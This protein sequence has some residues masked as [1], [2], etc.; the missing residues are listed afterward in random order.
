MWGDE[1]GICDISHITNAQNGKYWKDEPLEFFRLK[2]KEEA[3][4]KRKLE[5]KTLLFKTVADQ[6]G[7]IFDPNK[8]T[9]V[10]ARRFAGYKRP[11]LIT[12]DIERFD[13]LMKSDKVQI[14]W[15]GKPYPFD[16]G[17]IDTFNNLYYMSHLYKNM[18]VLTGHELHLSKLIKDG[19]DVWLNNPVVTREASGTSGMTA[20]M[21]A[22]I[23]LSTYDG[24]V[25]EFSNK[26]NSFIPPVAPADNAEIRD[27]TDIKNILDLI[28]N[29][30]I[31][32]YYNK[33]KKWNKMVLTSM[34]NVSD[35]FDSD[36]MAD[37]YY[38]KMYNPK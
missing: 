24:W 2:G 3:I 28:E 35:F 6:V 1:K 13:K 25:C 27:E 38:L 19:S 4:A 26:E 37:E 11:E 9:I 23:N 12:R 15:A 21:N 17:A 29:E 20:A 33:P 30:I 31:P 36:R 10:W 18:A 7:K 8:L 14:I 5:L 34:N 22:A 32:M 16:F